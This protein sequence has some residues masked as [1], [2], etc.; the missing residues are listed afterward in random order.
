MEKQA[1]ITGGSGHVGANL[2]RLLIN[3]GWKV[4]CLTHSDMRAFKGLNVELV[5]GE[6]L[7]SSF[8][9]E[10][11][12]GCSTVFHAAAVVG[13]ENIDIDMMH[14]VNVEGTKSMCAA[15]LSSQIKRFV[16]FS[17]IHAFQ[18]EPLNSKLIE[19]RLLVTDPK[20]PQYDLTK[21]SAELEV[22]KAHEKGLYTI[23]L[24][25]TGILG[26]YDFKPSRMGQLIINIMNQKMP[27][28]INAG[29]NWVDARDVCSAAIKSLDKAESGNN[30][31]LSGRWASFEQIAEMI[32]I[33]I[34]KKT[35][36][37]TLPFWL[38]YL[39]LPFSYL[40]SKIFLKR[41]L[42]S[43]GSLHALAIQATPSNKKAKERLV[44]NPR[45]LEDTINDT[46]DWLVKNDVH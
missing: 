31:I 25:P 33:K 13:V 44:F 43:K 5:K 16:Y 3:N 24:N 28:T 37:A 9:E 42:F 46:I 45:P 38:A 19:N 40:L 36:W 39:Y 21:A 27:L 22:K 2:I 41:P 23:V 8:L 11:M 29:F 6:I 26:P 15:A 20:A 30:Y 17:S 35:R 7:D 32:S 10:Q 34:N 4:R 14:R 12:Q 1:F 18:Q